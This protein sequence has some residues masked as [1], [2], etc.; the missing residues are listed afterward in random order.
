MTV[1]ARA[2]SSDAGSI[3]PTV[4]AAVKAV[5]P[6]LPVYGV[7]TMTERLDQ[8][9][10]EARFHLELLVSLGAVGLLL[11]AAGIYS[12]IAYFVTLR[13]H[14]I[15]VRMALGASVADIMRLMTWQGLRPVI[16]GAAL[17]AVAAVWATKLLR[18]SL[19]GVTSSDPLTFVAVTAVL[20]GVSLLAIIVPA[21]RVS[22][23]DPTTALHG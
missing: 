14:E 18:G 3:A 15:G 17:G 7:A 11:A 21:R 22:S 1:V 23:V 20:L 6:T 4:R 2:S 9:V 12:V 5:D 13:R 16:V 10:A 19:Y 8:S